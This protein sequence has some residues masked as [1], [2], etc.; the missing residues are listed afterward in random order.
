[1]NANQTAAQARIQARGRHLQSI[2]EEQAPPGRLSSAQSGPQP[3]ASLRG[4]P[5][6][7]QQQPLPPPPYAGCSVQPRTLSLYQYLG[8]WD[9]R[10]TLCGKKTRL[11]QRNE[12]ARV[13]ECRSRGVKASEGRGSVWP[14]QGFPLPRTQAPPGLSLILP[15]GERGGRCE[16]AQEEGEEGR[17]ICFGHGVPVSDLLGDPHRAFVL[18]GCPHPSAEFWSVKESA[19]FLSHWQAGKTFS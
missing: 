11:R 14:A 12:R 10:L 1:M 2:P 5:G 8:S 18:L 16:A 6:A 3:Q 4:G 19:R 9:P 15:P 13:S 7:K 17:G